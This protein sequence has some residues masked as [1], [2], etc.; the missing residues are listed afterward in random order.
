M[1]HEIVLERFLYIKQICIYFD[2]ILLCVNMVFITGNHS[3]FNPMLS[4][5]SLMKLLVE[6]VVVAA[7][8]ATDVFAETCSPA[9]ACCCRAA[10]VMWRL[11]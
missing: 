7:A 11:R 2:V 10:G 4:V 8:V 3:M 9:G 5:L 6:S 1:C